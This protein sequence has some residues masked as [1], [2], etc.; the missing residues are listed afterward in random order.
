MFLL[1][2]WRKHILCIAI[3]Y[4]TP[5]NEAEKKIGATLATGAL[6]TSERWHG[7]GDGMLPVTV[8]RWAPTSYKLS[9]EF[10]GFP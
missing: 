9:M 3:N 6:W 7:D 4:T 2:I 1:C 5:Q 10:P 8:A